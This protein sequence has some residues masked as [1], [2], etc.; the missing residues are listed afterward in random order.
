MTRCS[1]DHS[2]FFKKTKRGIII[3][4]VYVDDIVITGSDEEGMTVLKSHL[5]TNFMTKD[6]GKLKYFLGI[7]VARTKD[8]INLSQRK[9]VL[10]LLT[11]T[12][13][14]GCKPVET[15]MDVNRKLSIEEGELLADVEGYRRL[16]GK[17]I[18][19]TITRPDISFAVGVV[20][21]FMHSPRGPHMDA[22]IRILRY[23][24][25]APGRG[26]L[27]RVNGHLN[28]EG[29]TDADWAGSHSDRRSTT[30]YCTFFGGNLVTWKS[31]KQN[32]VARSSAESEYRAM[33][34]T[35][36]ELVWIRN[37]LKELGVPVK[38]PINLY[39]DN[40]AASH[41]AHNPVFHERTKHI[42]VDCHFIREK[43]QNGEMCTPHVSS[44]KQLADI[45]T[46]ALAKKVSD[47]IC[48]KLGMNDIYAPT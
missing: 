7:E 10:D 20:S 8:G 3:L 17:L 22:V 41:I 5:A 11:E 6:L 37:L 12:G 14:L 46:K 43:I 24:K 30:G 28:V 34:N 36:C 26:V 4:C 16:V 42:E 25:H 44:Q 38:E 29:Y 47:G 2:V 33:A 32:V 9:Y 27:Y 31:K 15:P 1:A 35:T 13:Y 48:N 23:L 18:Y 39:C 21:Q 45:F 40:Q 19:L